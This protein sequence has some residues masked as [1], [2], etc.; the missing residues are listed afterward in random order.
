MN[1]DNDE[2]N[3]AYRFIFDKCIM[4]NAVRS[5]ERFPEVSL[6]FGCGAVRCTLIGLN[7][8]CVPLVRGSWGRG[9]RGGGGGVSSA[10]RA[11]LTSALASTPAWQVL[12]LLVWSRTGRG[13]PPATLGLHCPF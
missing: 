9:G 7:W 1:D 10:V 13:F 4:A 12:A 2:E 8:A 5:C 11:E 6:F 3:V